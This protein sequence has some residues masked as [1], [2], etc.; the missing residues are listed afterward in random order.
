MVSLEVEEG[1]SNG[2]G[3][4]EDAS[5]FTGTDQDS[6]KTFDTKNYYSEIDTGTAP[7]ASESTSASAP[8][9]TSV[10]GGDQVGEGQQKDF[11]RARAFDSLKNLY[12]AYDALTRE[13]DEAIDGAVRRIDPET[14]RRFDDLTFKYDNEIQF[15]RH[16]VHS[17][18]VI[19][20]EVNRMR[21]ERIPC[22]L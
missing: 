4:D 7:R 1:K 13:I 17:L 12:R 18:E 15:S 16:V 10:S 14:M 9:S 2:Y 3:G 6:Q 22:K 21:S 19:V 20:Q 8:E 11:H 5:A